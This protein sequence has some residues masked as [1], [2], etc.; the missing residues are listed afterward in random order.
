MKFIEYSRGNSINRNFIV[1]IFCILAV[2]F[3]TASF[4]FASDLSE[5]V[6]VESD[7]QDVMAVADIQ[8]DV[9]EEGESSFA[10]LD[11]VI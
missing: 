3:S 1:V 11:E 5:N 7:N 8:Q 4:A 9:L 2:L 6:T 10:Q